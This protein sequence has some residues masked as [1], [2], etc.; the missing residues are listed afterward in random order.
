MKHMFY[1]TIEFNQPLNF[2]TSNVTNIKGMFSYA[3]KFNQ[4]VNFDISK[5]TTMSYMFANTLEFNQNISKWNLDKVEKCNFMFDNANAFLDKYNS[6]EPLP[7]NTN[8]IIEWFNNNRERMKMI[9]VKDKY[10]K[11]IDD[12]FKDIE[13]KNFTRNRY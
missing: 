1:N 6:G 13:G 9:D 10:G 8:D 3:I 5:V 12:F 7:T 11:E 2:D 4:P